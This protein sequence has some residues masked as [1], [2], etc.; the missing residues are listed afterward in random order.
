[1][2]RAFLQSRECVHQLQS[3]ALVGHRERS[4]AY[5][6]AVKFSLKISRRKFRTPTLGSAFC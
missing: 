5:Q 4:L 1:M 3:Q 2:N 6:D